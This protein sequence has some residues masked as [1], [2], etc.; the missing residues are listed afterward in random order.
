MRKG[1]DTQIRELAVAKYEA[2]NVPK[3][4]ETKEE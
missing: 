3:S 1:L 4:E 2:A